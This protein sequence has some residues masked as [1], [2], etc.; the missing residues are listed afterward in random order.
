MPVINHRAFGAIKFSVLDSR[1]HEEYR[2]GWQA[3][4]ATENQESY[5][6]FVEAGEEILPA[7]RRY[8]LP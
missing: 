2:G 3:H 8:A 6:A 5:L 7:T 1:A 4:L